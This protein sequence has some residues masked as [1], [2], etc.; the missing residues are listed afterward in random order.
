MR[1]KDDKLPSELTVLP[2]IKEI[3]NPMTMQLQSVPF[4]VAAPGAIDPRFASVTSSGGGYE[5]QV[6]G[7]LA[8][9]A[10]EQK[11]RA[12]V[13]TKLMS[14]SELGRTLEDYKAQFKRATAERKDAEL[15]LQNIRPTLER[16][17]AGR[18]EAERS[19][20]DK[21]AQIEDLTERLH[22]ANE[23]ILVARKFAGKLQELDMKLKDCREKRD[24]VRV[25]LRDEQ[26]KVN[27][28]SRELEQIEAAFMNS[29]NDL[30]HK[31]T[32]LE[33]ALSK[34]TEQTDEMDNNKDRVHELTQE[35]SRLTEEYNRL[36]KAEMELKAKKSQIDSRETTNVQSKLEYSEKL[37]R[38]NQDLET[39]H[40]TKDELTRQIKDKEAQLH[41]LQT[42]LKNLRF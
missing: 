30:E 19:L 20:R 32:E 34:N 22:D 38:L 5:A 28:M 23:K 10:A 33:R 31:R 3:C 40:Q 21:R 27:N 14:M 12:F 16:E 29:E 18:E 2:G 24:V 36:V 41:Q 9:I 6:N 1:N 26:S 8:R 15:R 4:A 7:L 39:D 17:R 25:Q 37:S 13:Q 42:E 35:K 11:A